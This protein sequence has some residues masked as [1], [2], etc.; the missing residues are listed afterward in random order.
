MAKAKPSG[1]ASGM[2]VLI[3]L[4]RIQKVFGRRGERV[5]LIMPDSAEPVVLVPL[6]EYEQFSQTKL[7][8][9]ATGAGGQNKTHKNPIKPNNTAGQR[10]QPELVDPLQGGLEDDDQYFPEPL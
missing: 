9:A 3:D 4:A 1:K 6:N 8:L 2:P 10:P 5:V 7:P